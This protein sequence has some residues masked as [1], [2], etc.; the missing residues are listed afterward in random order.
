VVARQGVEGRA[1]SRGL[2]L[3][4]PVGTKPVILPSNHGDFLGGVYGRILA[5]V[6][7]I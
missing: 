1:T 7:V 3:R 4:E 6:C 5:A 2:C